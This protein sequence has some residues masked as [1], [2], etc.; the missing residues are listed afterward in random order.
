MAAPPAESEFQVLA[1]DRMVDVAL[2]PGGV[3]VGGL[4]RADGAPVSGTPVE[5][6]QQGR[7]VASATTD[8]RG[9]FAISGIRGGL[10]EVTTGGSSAGCRAWTAETAPPIAS[11]ALLLVVTP[12]VRG[13]E[14]SFNPRHLKIC[15]LTALGVSTAAL[16]TSIVLPLVL[17]DDDPYSS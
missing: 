10:Y 1:S 7:M 4:V 5:V 15:A 8:G 17:D 3:L 13:Q 11:E 16:I 2:R 14:V 6:R 9:W 12:V